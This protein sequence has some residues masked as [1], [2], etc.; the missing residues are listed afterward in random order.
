MSKVLLIKPRFF[1]LDFRAITHPMGL[2][3]LGATLK[4]A[5]HEPKIHDCS[6]DYKDLH[7]L[8]HTITEWKP[9]FIGISI[10]I[11]ELEQTKK[12][13]GIIRKIM[14]DVPVTF[15]GPWPSANPQESIKTFGA[16]FV[17]LGEGE[18]VFPGL[19]EAINKGLPTNSIAGTASSVNGNIE[20]NPGQQLTEDELNALP[21]P[22]WELLDHKHY[23][24][25]LSMAS[26]GRRP[27]MTILTSR[28]CPFK[29]AYCHNTMGKT[30]RK[31]SAQSV[32]AEIEELRFRHGFTEFEITDDCFNLDRKRMYEILTGI[33]DRISDVKL[34]FPNGL[35]ADELKPEDM[36]LF[37][38]A[39]TVS[40]CF[41]IETSTPRLQKMINKNLNID[42][43]VLAINAAVKEGIFSTGYFMIGF[44]TETYQEASDTVEFAA[45]SSLHRAFFNNA[46]P[47]EGTALADMAADAL[48]KRNNFDPN[49]I[50]Y[51]SS[52]SIAAMTDRDLTRI[53]RLAYRRFYLNP[54]RIAR[55]IM[56]LP[57]VFFLLPW[58]AFTLLIRILP[59]R[60][61][62]A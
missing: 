34:H 56:H 35:R 9:D 39:G 31:R 49:N 12:I 47:F 27:Y 23:E 3:Y 22:A 46:T 59:I 40:A 29:C 17:V 1:S 36:A 24:K 61:S 55:L 4:V 57:R 6:L 33:R 21:F 11:T 26:V 30:F 53:F 37:K 5:G 54:K 50:N 43:A 20:V 28:G 52:I 62:T 14:P 51:F 13:M 32:I 42:K 45:H 7:I 48:K 2:I 44:P 15:G 58:Y 60:R 10:I 16:D 25:N 38:Q 19:I 8:K 41:S 18:L